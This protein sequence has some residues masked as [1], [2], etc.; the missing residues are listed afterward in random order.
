M[1]RNA[2]RSTSRKRNPP[3]P[4][5]RLM[6]TPAN[7]TTATD[8]DDIMGISPE[9]PPIQPSSFRGLPSPLLQET[10]PFKMPSDQQHWFSIQTKK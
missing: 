9:V 5:P 3:V 4:G 1:L 10:S 6:E 7:I 8:G 2:K